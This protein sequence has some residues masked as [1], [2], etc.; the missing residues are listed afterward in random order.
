MEGASNRLKETRQQPTEKSDLEKDSTKAIDAISLRLKSIDLNKGLEAA[1]ARYGNDANLTIA[2]SRKQ[3]CKRQNVPVT[4]EMQVVS[5]SHLP[6]REVYL[7]PESGST[8]EL[9]SRQ[10]R[11]KMMRIMNWLK[12]LNYLN[13]E[14]VERGRVEVEKTHFQLPE[15][16]DSALI[17]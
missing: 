6:L 17:V 10:H 3:V 1:S 5:L 8:R 9:A 13:E 12:E 11:D 7:K 16:K 14:D 4:R 2:L 15:I